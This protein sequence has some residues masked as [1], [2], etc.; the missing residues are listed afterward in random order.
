MVYDGISGRS[1]LIYWQK[2]LLVSASQNLKANLSLGL[3]CLLAASFSLGLLPLLLIII[4]PSSLPFGV[5]A[6]CFGCLHNTKEALQ[7][8]SL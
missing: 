2:A 7:I 8:P 1:T 5:I 3:G 4:L 6:L